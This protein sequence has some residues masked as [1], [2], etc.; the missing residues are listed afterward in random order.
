MAD[1]DDKK[2]IKFGKLI[3]WKDVVICTEPPEETTEHGVILDPKS[4]QDAAKQPQ[5]G[6]V[7]AVGPSSDTKKKVNLQ[8]GDLLFFERYTSN[9]I[10][11]KGVVYNFVRF[12]FIMG[13]KKK[14]E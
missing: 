10:E 14:E 9:P 12:K 11:E 13:A 8:P 6:L 1:Q 2:P 7:F 3:P 4:A 5:K